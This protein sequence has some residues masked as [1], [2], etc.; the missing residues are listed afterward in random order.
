MGDFYLN[1]IEVWIFL[2]NFMPNFNG[3]IKIGIFPNAGYLNKSV[4]FIKWA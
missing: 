4:I 3:P 1:N 2:S